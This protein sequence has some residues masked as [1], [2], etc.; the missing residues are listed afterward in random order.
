MMH[1]WSLAALAR[2]C[3]RRRRQLLLLWLLG[4]A[5][6]IALG[7]RFA[8]PADNGFAGG[9][10]ESARAQALLDRHFPG[11]RGDTITLAI[12][13][14]QGVTEPSVRARVDRMIS[15]LRG[16]PHVTGV[17]SPYLAPGQISADRRTAFAPAQLDVTSD[18][19][20][21][22]PVTKLISAARAASG[23]GLT[24]ALGGPAVSAAETPGGGPSEGIGL[25]AAVV[26]LL[27]AF[28]SVLAMGLPIV[29]ALF[30]I[31]TGLSAIALLGH[32]L[33][34]PSFS[35]IVA[36]LIGL[37]VGVDYALFIVTRYRESLAGG[38][39]PEEATVTAIT[40]AGR[41]VLFAGSTVV[42]ALL[43]LF[44]MRQPLLNGVAVA[45]GVT[46]LMTMITAVTLLPALLGFAGRSID[47]L[48]VPWP[49]ASRSGTRAPLAERWA[50]VVQRR[51]VV[52]ALAAGAVL[53]VLAVPAL[54][55]RLS[56]PDSGTQPHGTSGYASHRILA[57]GFGAGYEAPLVVVAEAAG[58]AGGGIG[59]AARPVADAV[60]RAPGVAAVTP[61]RVSA[62]GAAAVF[63]AY[64]TTGVQD[65]ATS[66]LV[67]L[68]RDGVLPA[69]TAGTGVRVHVGGPNAGTIDF[70]DSVGER[71]PWLIAIV[72]G[73]SLLLLVALVRSVVIALQAAVMNV[74]SIA[75]AYG[76]LVAVVQWG[77]L[78]DLFGF[79]TAMPV[80]AWV[81]LFMFPI[82]FGLSMDYQVFLVSRMREEYAAGSAT[83]EAVTRGLA[84]TA[85]VITAA[86]AIMVMVFLS[87]LFGADVG[88]KQIGLGLGVAVLIDATVVRLVLVPAI[89]ELCGAANWWLPGRP[90]RRPRPAGAR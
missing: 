4:A 63:I 79:P 73:L 10:S 48:R 54:S 9:T 45:A 22:A 34:A 26:V 49:A 42:I 59:A 68:L 5:V 55:M 28:G 62:D 90:A 2:R 14:D 78:R 30:G 44:V 41:A 52:A 7:A 70:A 87:V 29:T 65:R 20:P 58:G 8:A 71:L 76:V 66:H 13:A 46:V 31:G 11:Q 35:P 23:G 53:L 27:I 50:G 37:G 74:L 84:R 75:A 77:W 16:A 43:G 67:H 83:R 64:P 57:R 15:K 19:M 85:R 88:V 1:S 86:A 25:L 60:R 18:D 17:S 39:D 82:L 61:P 72:V 56:F 36:G 24:L 80:T 69:A 6:V 38:A 3:Y 81:P 51:P 32:L 21:K 47:R 89:M 12:H 40:T 33:P